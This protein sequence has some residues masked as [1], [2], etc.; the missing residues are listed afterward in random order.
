MATLSGRPGPAYR[1]AMHRPLMIALVLGLGFLVL[2]WGSQAA[3]EPNSRNYAG[4]KDA[5]IDALIERVIYAKDREE[6]VAATKALDRVLLWHHYMVPQFYSDVFRTA[7]WD[8]F[9]RPEKMPTYGM[10]AFPTIWW[11]DPDKAAKTRR[12]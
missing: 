10:S 11:W 12:A 2:V 6:L 9:A 5:G 3:D 4:I 8:R 1:S 7:R